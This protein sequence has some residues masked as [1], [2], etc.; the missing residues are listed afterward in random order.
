MRDQPS[1]KASFS[2]VAGRRQ[3]GGGAQ[4][5]RHYDGVGMKNHRLKYGKNTEREREGQERTEPRR[6]NMGKKKNSSLE[7]WLALLEISSPQI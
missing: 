2:V 4:K 5:R 3:N 7:I 1:R 6:L